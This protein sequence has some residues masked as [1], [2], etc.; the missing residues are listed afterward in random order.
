MSRKYFS[1]SIPQDTILE[2]YSYKDSNFISAEFIC[3]NVRISVKI[4][5]VT[6][7]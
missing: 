6:Q 7:I 3:S 4:L 1:V 5:N 2:S